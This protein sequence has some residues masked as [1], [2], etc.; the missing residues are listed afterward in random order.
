MCCFIY[1]FIWLCSLFFVTPPY[2][3]CEIYLLLTKTRVWKRSVSLFCVCL[4]FLSFFLIRKRNN[5]NWARHAFKLFAM[6]ILCCYSIERLTLTATVLDSNVWLNSISIVTWSCS[7]VSSLF[8]YKRMNIN[9][10]YAFCVDSFVCLLCDVISVCLTASL[11][12][13]SLSYK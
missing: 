8:V 2:L 9:V 3:A 10:V 11:R 13:W 1:L 4:S 5:Q 12:L 7:A 6:C